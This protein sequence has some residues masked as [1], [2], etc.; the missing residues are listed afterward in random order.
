M[1][2]RFAPPPACRAFPCDLFDCCVVVIVIIVV[3]RRCCPSLLSVVLSSPP[4]LPLPPLRLAIVATAEFL[5][6]D[7]CLPSSALPH[8]CGGSQLP[9]PS[10]ASSTAKYAL[11]H[12]QPSALSCANPCALQPS[13]HPCALSYL[14]DEAKVS[15]ALEN[16]DNNN[17][18]NNN[19]KK[20]L[21]AIPHPH[22]LK[23]SRSNVI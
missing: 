12:A 16:N 13:A 5:K 11:P 8:D 6:A 22:T 18:I 17:N 9:P 15:F 1:V 21:P 7:C 10:S 20:Y 4:S 14:I 23:S 3:V 19:N 2:S